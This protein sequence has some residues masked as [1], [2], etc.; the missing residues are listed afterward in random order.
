[1][2]SAKKFKNHYPNEDVRKHESSNERDKEEI[3]AYVNKIKSLL[4]THPE[5]SKKLAQ[6]ISELINKKDK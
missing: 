3:V 4:E 5:N 2:S 1:M 6:I